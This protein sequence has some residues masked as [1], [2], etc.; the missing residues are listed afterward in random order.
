MVV[1]KMNSGKLVAE[2]FESATIFF[3][4]VVEFGVIAKKC[5]ALEVENKLFY[6]YFNIFLII[7]HYLVLILYL[8]FRYTRTIIKNMY[9][10]KDKTSIEIYYMSR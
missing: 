3:S 6:N 8:K 2:N 10:K 9:D 1:E 4:S 7:W 5:S